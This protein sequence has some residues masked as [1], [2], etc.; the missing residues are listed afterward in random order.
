MRSAHSI[1]AALLVLPT[2]ACAEPVPYLNVGAFGNAL[3]DGTP[4]PPYGAALI[5]VPLPV[6]RREEERLSLIPGFGMDFSLTT[7]NRG[8]YFFLA[9]DYLVTDWLGIDL[10]GATVYDFDPAVGAGGQPHAFFVGAG[11]GVTLFLPNGMGVSPGMPVLCNVQDGS[12]FLSPGALVSV[13]L[14]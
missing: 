4:L 1:L 6:S 2:L 8:V 14:R 11:P 10:I 7:G 3:L 13:P 5:S 9:A 12:C